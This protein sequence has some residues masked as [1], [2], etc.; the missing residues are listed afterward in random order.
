MDAGNAGRVDCKCDLDVA[1][2]ETGR[3]KCGNTQKCICME[4]ETLSTHWVVNSPS[5]LEYLNSQ[6]YQVLLGCHAF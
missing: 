6:S 5:E 2:D 4:P 3:H 1:K